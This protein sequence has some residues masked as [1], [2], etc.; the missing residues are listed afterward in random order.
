MSLEIV[1]YCLLQNADEAFP[2]LTIKVNALHLSLDIW[3]ATRLFKHYIGKSSKCSTWPTLPSFIATGYIPEIQQSIEALYAWMPRSSLYLYVGSLHSH[4][5]SAN[6]RVA[7]MLNDFYSSVCVLA[8]AFSVDICAVLSKEFANLSSIPQF[9]ERTSC[10]MRYL[11]LKSIDLIFGRH[12]ALII[13]CCAFFL[14]RLHG[15]E[16]PPKFRGIAQTLS[17]AF[18]NVSIDN[19]QDLEWI[20]EGEQVRGRGSAREFYNTCFLRRAEMWDPKEVFRGFNKAQEKASGK[21]RV[22]LSNLN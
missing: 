19:F 20:E 21:D 1:N 12:L 22:A 16:P 7:R 14:A 8:Q 13:A 11:L 3:N 5:V 6:I 2:Y 17:K 4:G 15:I 18:P 10:I 9:A